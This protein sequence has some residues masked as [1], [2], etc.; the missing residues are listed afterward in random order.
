MVSTEEIKAKFFAKYKDT[1]FNPDEVWALI[2]PFLR[3]SLTALTLRPVTAKPE[4]Q[5]DALVALLASYKQ[6]AIDCTDAFVQSIEPPEPESP[7]RK[8]LRD[9]VNSYGKEWPRRP[10]DNPRDRSVVEIVEDAK[11]LLGIKTGQE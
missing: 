2:E 1:S 9:L 7:E 6:L 8:L 3:T 11:I 4:L 10:L 5:Y